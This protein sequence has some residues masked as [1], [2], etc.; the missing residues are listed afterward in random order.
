MRSPEDEDDEDE[1]SSAD[2]D[3]LRGGPRDAGDRDADF[4]EFE[5]STAQYSGNEARAG[6]QPVQ[7]QPFDEAMELSDSDGNSAQASPMPR[8]GVAG[9]AGGAN[10]GGSS[11]RQRADA[12]TNQPF[13]EAMELSSEGSVD[14][15]DDDDDES[16]SPAPDAPSAKAQMGSSTGMASMGSR[17]AAPEREQR[18]Q[19]PSQL[20]TMATRPQERKMPDSKGDDDDES[21]YPD[22]ADGSGTGPPVPEGM[23][24]P[25]EYANLPVSAEIKEL[26]QYITRYKPH[27]IELETKMRPFIPD[28]IPAVGD[29][30]PFIKVPRPDGKVDNLGLVTLDEPASVQSDPT[31][32]TLQLRATT[33]SSGTQPMLVRSIEHA[34]K[35]PKAIT[36]WI[37]SISDLHRH[38]PAPSVRYSKPM[39]DIEALMQ[40]WPAPMEEMLESHAL[41]DADVSLDLASY[42]RM[43]CAMLDIPVYGSLTEALHI[44]FTL[45]SDFKANVHFQQQLSAEEQQQMGGGMGGMGGGGG[46]GGMGGG[47]M[48]DMGGDYG[49]GMG[50]YDGGAESLM[51]S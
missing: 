50:G 37:N 24:D 6:T 49:G 42:V 36:N 11:S 25:E 48:G 29:I 1:L 15:N 32:L 39:P 31:V 16:P 30:D 2:E 38:K 5:D 47:G 51:I 43:V 10:R 17:P 33:K 23:Y 9:G 35:N 46:M 27:N 19:M 20:E 7:N 18:E 3:G 26:F 14:G 41:P 8:G 40:I 13:D 44:L 34:E 28:Y 45:Y 22:G 12:V 21:D 4:D